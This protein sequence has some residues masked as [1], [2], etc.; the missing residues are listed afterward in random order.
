MQSETSTPSFQNFL[1]LSALS[2][3]LFFLSTLGG[4]W[5]SAIIFALVPLLI[6][7]D[8]ESR[9]IYNVAIAI[10][11]LAV[12]GFYYDQSL[13][14]PLFTLLAWLL[15]V[16]AQP[17][18]GKQ[19][20]F[21]AFIFLWL[22]A[23]CIIYYLPIS[24]S[25]GPSLSFGLHEIPFLHAGFLVLGFSGISLLVVLLNL[26]AAF[27]FLAYLKNKNLRPGLIISWLL[28]LLCPLFISLAADGTLREFKWPAGDYD[29]LRSAD[30]FLA[31][32]SF[33]IAFFLL[34]FALVRKLL[35]EKNSDDR[36]T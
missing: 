20:S 1:T 2:A 31:R 11:P 5:S 10:I 30:R 12:W 6:Y 22:S 29:L 7:Q 3:L 35:P 32:M 34:L 36:F 26:L 17:L 13:H 14:I 9:A 25:L 27:F 28:F 16:L 21:L 4:F 8:L 18:W 15:F 23:E 33:F 24:A 19:R